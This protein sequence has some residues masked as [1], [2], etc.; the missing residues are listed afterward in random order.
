MTK[1][2]K[3]VCSVVAKKKGGDKRQRREGKFP[4]KKVRD[5][6]KKPRMNSQRDR[7]KTN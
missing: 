2:M 6:I 1:K 7:L 4:I 3:A 5:K